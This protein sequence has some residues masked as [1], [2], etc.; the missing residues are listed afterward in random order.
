MT[1]I[2]LVIGVISILAYQRNMYVLS[3]VSFMALFTNVFMFYP[4]ENE[5]IR[6][7]DIVLVSSVV[8]LFLNRNKLYCYKKDK[9]YRY[10]IS[11]L[12]FTL[13]ELVYTVITNAESI[14]FALKIQRIPSL[15][16]FAL[17]IRTIPLSIIKK[18][19]K[20]AFFIT[21]INGVCFYLEFVGIDLLPDVDPLR[22]MGSL[23]FLSSCT[24]PVFTVIFL[25]I[26]LSGMFE[27][28]YKYIFLIFFLGILILSFVRTWLYGFLLCA[29]VLLYQMK[30]DIKT[31][32]RYLVLGAIFLPIV[33]NVIDKKESAAS[34]NNHSDIENILSGDFLTPEN[35]INAA[36]G[37]FA[38]RISM[39]VERFYYLIDNPEKLLLGVGA[40]HEGSPNNRFNFYL[41]T[42]NQM[43]DRCMIESGDITWVPV[44]LRYGI[45]GTLLYLYFFIM[46]VINF[47]HR[48]D[49]YC[50]I[51]PIAIMYFIMSFSGAFF[52]RAESYLIICLLL[53]ISSRL[54]IEYK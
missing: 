46:L 10:C 47:I 52:E 45:L 36:N 43:Y 40:I 24:I 17:V 2:Y 39:C 53:G 18:F 22:S 25:F 54:E 28:K 16:C 50:I 7:T 14:S 32:F 12:L 27:I 23:G 5:G 44:V 26:C 9:Y 3:L 4:S 48:K 41:G 6:G 20:V 19:M 51:A 31:L 29:L 34:A 8:I 13:L 15:I 42:S 35:N 21:I 1:I 33:L 11:V 38:F 49:E 30:S 37:T